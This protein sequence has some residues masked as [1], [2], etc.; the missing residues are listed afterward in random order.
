M[1]PLGGALKALLG[2]ALAW[3]WW[4]GKLTRLT[5]KATGILASTSATS[6]SSTSSGTGVQLIPSAPG[7]SPTPNPYG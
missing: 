3:A 2:L 1:S 5:D 4:T 7:G 6:A